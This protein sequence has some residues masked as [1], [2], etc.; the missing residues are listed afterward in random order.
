MST[1]RLRIKLGKADF[2]EQLVSEMSRE[3][4]LDA[5][6]NCVLSGKDKPVAAAAKAAPI[7]G[8][9]VELERQ[10]LEFETKKFE[11]E[12]AFRQKEL[13]QQEKRRQEELMLQSLEMSLLRSGGKK[14]LRRRD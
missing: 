14:S 7:V 4:L 13:E 1:E 3:Q 10:R 12:L 5:W 6:A 8:Y 11:A 9:D 2:D